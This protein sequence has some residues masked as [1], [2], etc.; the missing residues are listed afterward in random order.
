M[1][2][3]L[4]GRRFAK[5][6]RAQL[7]LSAAMIALTVPFYASFLLLSDMRLAMSAL[8][9]SLIVCNF[10]Q[11][12][13]F[14]LMQ[15]PV[16]D[17]KRAAALAIAML[18]ANLIGFGIGL[19]IVGIVSDLLMPALGTGSLRYAM[20]AVS[21]VALWAAFHCWRAVR[22]VHPD[23]RAMAPDPPNHFELQLET[24]V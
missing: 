18:L 1:G 3:Y 21:S 11:G 9:P 24:P 12:P 2:G 8:V 23:L 4:G 13:T 20:L 15:R 5:D 19:R 6:A 22:T 17:D 7:R 14:A 10:F 16:P